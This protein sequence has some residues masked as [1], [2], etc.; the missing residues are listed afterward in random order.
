[1]TSI[2]RKDRE[3]S[4]EEAMAIA[5]T[6]E[7]AVVSMVD[8]TGAPYCVPVSIALD[9]H[10]TGET[11]YFHSA[12]VG[13]KNDCLNAN[14]KVC[15][16]CVGNTERLSDEFSTKYESAV[17]R[18]SAHLVENAEEK[19]RALRLICERHTPAYMHAFDDAVAKMLDRTAIWAI[20]VESVTGKARR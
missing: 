11:V 19:C 12:T 8:P 15:L 18:G 9:R 4:R 6:C 17:L 3:I 2:R 1:M 10:E 5:S 20:E 16:L 13:F 7:Y 14:P